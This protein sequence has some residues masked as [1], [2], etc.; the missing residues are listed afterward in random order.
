MEISA[1]CKGKANLT[2]AKNQK[3]IPLIFWQQ[4]GQI[5]AVQNKITTNYLG[6][7]H[8]RSVWNL[9]SSFLAS[10]EFSPAIF[11]NSGYAHLLD[12]PF[13]ILTVKT[14]A[15]GLSQNL[16]ISMLQC[17]LFEPKEPR[18]QPCNSSC[19]YKKSFTLSHIIKPFKYVNKRTPKYLEDDC[20][21]CF[22]IF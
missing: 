7:P 16:S 20:Q 6:Y 19:Y 9:P 3:F 18:E 5:F 21:K 22:M 12:Q 13:T 4:L 11:F 1:K 2:K 8:F 14:R 15:S 17:I 10:Y